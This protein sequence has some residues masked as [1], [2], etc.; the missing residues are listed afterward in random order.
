MNNHNTTRTVK[1]ASFTTLFCAM[2]YILVSL[3]IMAG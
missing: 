3:S 1:L 2:A